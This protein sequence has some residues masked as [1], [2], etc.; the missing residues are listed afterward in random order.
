MS[1]PSSAEA[2]FYE[3]LGKEPAER[4]A[5]LDRACAGN[6]P[7]RPEVME[8]CEPLTGGTQIDHRP[9]PPDPN[10]FEKDMR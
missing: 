2:V 7:L 9:L 8:R 6:E 4:A 3:A 5:F 1:E 10:N